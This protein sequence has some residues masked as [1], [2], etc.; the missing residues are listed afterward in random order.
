MC[1]N[2]TFI[3]LLA[4][5]QSA[6]V[7]QPTAAATTRTNGQTTPSAAAATKMPADMMMWQQL[8]TAQAQAQMMAAYQQQLQQQQHGL[9]EIFRQLG[10]MT[11]KKES[12]QPPPPAAATATIKEGAE[13]KL[14]IGEVPKPVKTPAAAPVTNN[15]LEQAMWRML[16]A[17]MLQQQNALT[18]TTN[19][20]KKEPSNGVLD[21]SH[22]HAKAEPCESLFTRK[23]NTVNLGTSTEGTE[24]TSSTPHEGQ[25]HG[26]KRAPPSEG[27]A[28]LPIQLG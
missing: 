8:I 13:L 12:K 22:K 20:Y 1:D 21:L 5:A 18:K 28:R 7:P 10:E 25:E 17:Q 4:A 19:G 9:G 16:A 6:Q 24:T 15:A 11:K 26:K 23:E 14:E 27:A 2:N 3:R